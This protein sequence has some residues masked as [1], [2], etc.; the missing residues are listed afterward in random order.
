MTSPREFFTEAGPRIRKTSSTLGIGDVRV[1]EGSRFPVWVFDIDR[2]RVIWANQPALGIWAA[3]SM[4]EL[5]GRDLGADMS[6]SVRAQLLQFQAAFHTGAHFDEPWTIFPRGTPRLLLCRFRGCLLTDGRMAM[7]CEAQAIT[8]NDA[9]MLKSNQALLYTAVMV[10]TYTKAGECTYA[11]PAAR[12]AFPVLDLPLLPRFR[13]AALQRALAGETGPQTEGRYLSEV[14][15]SRG[16]RIHEVEVRQSF[17]P[18]DGQQTFL[19]TEIDVTEKEKAKDELAI[20]ATRDPLTGLR[21]RTYLASS[22]TKFITSAHQRGHGV[23]LLLL[24]LDRF[25]FVNDTLGHAAGDA[26]LQ[27]ISTRMEAVVPKSALLA[28]FGGDEFCCLLSG[29]EGERSFLRASLVILKELR[30]PLL[31]ENNDLSV[32]ASIGL[33]LA[34]GPQSTFED[35]LQKADLALFAA[36]SDGGGKVRAFRPQMADRSH[37]FLQVDT[38]LRDA[39]ARNRLELFYQPRISFATGRIV[40]AEALIRLNTSSG[41]LVLPTE[42]IPIA[43]ATGQIAAIGRWVLREAVRQLEA[44]RSAGSTVNLSINV[45]PKQFSDPAFLALL[46]QIRPRIDAGPGDIELE[47][48]ENILIDSDRRLRRVLHQISQLGYAFAIDDF[49]TAYSNLASL[50]RYPISC[51]K[52]DRTLIAHPDFRLLVTSVMTIGRAFGARIIAEGVETEPQRQWLKDN[53]CDEFQGFLFSRPVPFAD[54][55]AMLNAQAPLAGVEMPRSL[56]G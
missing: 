45:S 52:I 2:A 1:F 49:G 38:E 24:D 30:R 44:L 50:T 27:A 33:S 32:S 7:L 28:R 8:P 25:K 6:T 56:Q 3:E 22:A 23:A 20:L 40:A 35:L 36:K 41:V 17:D 51:I 26:L 42:F 55:L 19:I 5:Q 46:R 54:L 16:L 18:I 11:N 14:E 34:E 43:E 39:L 37:R 31:I 47:I 15:T 12:M 4:A 10:T 21:N 53:H 9:D 48:T 29:P 13:N